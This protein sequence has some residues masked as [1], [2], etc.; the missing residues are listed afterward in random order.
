MHIYMSDTI[1]FE[2]T[3]ECGRCLL[4]GVATDRCF[5]MVPVKKC[6]GEIWLQTRRSGLSFCGIHCFK[7]LQ[8]VPYK[9]MSYLNQASSST[10]VLADVNL[11][12]AAGCIFD[13]LNGP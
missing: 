13:R 9:I 12:L 3:L 11:D 8:P 6:I 1:T 7:Q 4:A 2:V 5:L 10:R